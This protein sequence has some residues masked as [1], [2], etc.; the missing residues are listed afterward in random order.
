[1]KVEGPPLKAMKLN[2]NLQNEA[3]IYSQSFQS[4]LKNSQ[5]NFYISSFGKSILGTNF[6]NVRS[7][8]HTR[9]AII[10]VFF[11]LILLS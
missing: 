3:I 6:D 2:N 11:F 7:R 9:I 4:E 10:L 1:M 5:H 8:D